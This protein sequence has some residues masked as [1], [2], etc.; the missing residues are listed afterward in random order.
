MG[1]TVVFSY[2]V[3][4]ELELM[5]MKHYAPNRCLYMKVAK[6]RTRVRSAEISHPKNGSVKIFNEHCRYFPKK[7]I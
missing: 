6:L 5:F 4:V 7:K 3:S 2:H 1:S